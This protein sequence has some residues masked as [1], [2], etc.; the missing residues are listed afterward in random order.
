MYTRNSV[1]MKH[2]YA[3]ILYNVSSFTSPFCQKYNIR[4]SFV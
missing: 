2:V 3:M 1:Y 4:L